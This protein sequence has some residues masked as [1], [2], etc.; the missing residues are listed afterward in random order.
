VLVHLRHLLASPHPYQLYVDHRNLVHIFS[1]DSRHSTPSNGRLDR[2][3]A[4]LQD[5]P[6]TIVHLPGDEN[7]WADLLSRWAQ[8]TPT[9]QMNHS[10]LSSTSY[11][12]PSCV[13][14]H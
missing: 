14:K 11:C 4:T 2:W 13:Y 10:P 5:L 1:P 7:V 3:A 9:T 6:Y 8:P 12:D